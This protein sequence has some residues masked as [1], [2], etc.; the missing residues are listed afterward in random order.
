VE[1][2][3]AEYKTER[4]ALAKIKAE[5]EKFYRENH[6][7]VASSKAKQLADAIGQ[8]QR[9]FSRSYFPEMKANWKAFPDNLDHVY[10][11]GCFRC[12]DDKH[13]SDSGHKIS[14]D[15]NSCHTILSQVKP[16]GGQEVN[17]NGLVFRHPVDIGEEWKTMLCRD[18]HNPQE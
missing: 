5:V 17:K 6:A 1:V 2:L 8:I 11:L 4:E 12:H 3:E 16:G 15:C 14:K 7:E 10:S 13:V 18:C 9:I